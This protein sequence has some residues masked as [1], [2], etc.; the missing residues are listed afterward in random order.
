M[1]IPL[2][3][4]EDMKSGRGGGRRGTGRRYGKYEDALRPHVAGLVE[5]IKASKNL[6]AAKQ[7]FI[8]VKVEDIAKQIG[9]GGKHETSIYWGTKSVLF[10]DPEKF[11]DG[12]GIVVTTGQTKAGEPLLVMRM[13]T[14][15]DKLPPS[16]V[17]NMAKAGAGGAGGEAAGA[18]TG[19]EDEPTGEE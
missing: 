15:A 18:E 8:A 10:G 12:S 17:K 16:L 3:S 7:Q 9:M 1:E 11:E 4:V 6:N 13:R 19:S 5:A 14:A 2:F